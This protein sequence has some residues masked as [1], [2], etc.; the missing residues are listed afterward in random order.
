MRVRWRPG[1]QGGGALAA[2]ARAA[3]L[4]LASASLF[5]LLNPLG[6][7]GSLQPRGTPFPGI[8]GPRAVASPG[9]VGGGGERGPGDKLI[10]KVI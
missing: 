10:W 6:T 2:E 5:E 3:L 1:E 7:G 8:S 4:G 9:A